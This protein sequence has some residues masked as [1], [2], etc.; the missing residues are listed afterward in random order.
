VEGSDLHRIARRI[1]DTE[2]VFLANPVPEPVTVSLPSGSELVVWDPVSLERTALADS[3]NLTLSPCGSVFLV[4][5]GAA[6]TSLSAPTSER[7]L[8]RP[9]QL[10][11]RGA[12]RYALPEGPRPWTDLGTEA[13]GFS[14]VGSY[15]TELDLDA[16]AVGEG[17][18]FL[19]ADVGDIARVRVNGIDCGVLWTAPFEAEVTQ[20]LH[21]G[22][23][24][25]ELQVA[26][27]WMNRLIAAAATSAG[28]LFEPVRRIYAADAT[29]RPA[30]VL[31]PV[32]L[33]FRP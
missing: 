33:V 26:N 9:W 3:G 12:G 24:V 13:A 7:V 31:G 11:L 8:D 23:N 15:V 18:A 19:V 6:A 5:G 30:G 10:T 25:V 20:A 17:R 1:G 2:V 28:E 29:P 22:R 4:G 14:G 32:R 21:P 16:V 27:P